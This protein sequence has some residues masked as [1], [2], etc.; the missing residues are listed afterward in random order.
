MYSYYSSIP[1]STS[2]NQA[3]KR[4]SYGPESGWFCK[5]CGCELTAATVICPKCSTMTPRVREILN[6]YPDRSPVK[7]IGHRY[8]KDGY[9]CPLCHRNH[10]YPKKEYLNTPI[11]AKKKSPAADAYGVR[12]IPSNFLISPE[13]KIVAKNLRGQDVIKKLAE[14]IER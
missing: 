3:K 5:G 10:I 12:S 4:I 11:N 9:T 13:G 8:E 2:Y 14:V 7:F 6:T 1:T